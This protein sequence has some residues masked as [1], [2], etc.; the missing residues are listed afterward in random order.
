MSAPG[1]LQKQAVDCRGSIRGRAPLGIS[2]C[3]S[4]S[5]DEGPG[6][7]HFEGGAG[8]GLGSR[9]EVQP[10]GAH[11]VWLWEKGPSGGHGAGM[12]GCLRGNEY[13][14]FPVD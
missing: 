10:G 6:E 14:P 7:G 5:P 1:P 2:P 3:A 9:S 11:G 13:I 12:A 4:A 8:L